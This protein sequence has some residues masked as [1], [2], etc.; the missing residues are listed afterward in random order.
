MSVL[1]GEG[2]DYTLEISGVTDITT[3]K[4]AMLPYT[5]ALS[6]T[7]KTGVNPANVTVNRT[8]NNAIVINYPEVMAVSGEGSIV[9]P[10]KYF[11]S[12]DSGAVTTWKSLPSDAILNITPDGKSTV[13]TFPSDIDV[14]TINN[15]RIQLVKDLAGNYMT[16]L[17]K[18]VVLGNAS[19]PTVSKVTITGTKE[20]SVEFASKILAN[21]INSSD[22][23]ITSGTSTLSVIGS[24]LA[25]DGKT[26]VLTLADSNEMNENG[27]MGTSKVAVNLE[28]I[29]AAT[30]ASPE[31]KTIAARWQCFNS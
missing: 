24:K 6:I 11:Y 22:F 19:Q 4:N 18:D 10:G 1:L 21:T 3:L 23:K 8:A 27:T 16:G 30:T 9:D 25:T 31:G 29:S 13:I 26:V 15:F 20:I 14:N 17:T 28:I 5:K 7:D 12:K 2:K